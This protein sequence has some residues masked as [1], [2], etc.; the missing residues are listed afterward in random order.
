MNKRPRAPLHVV[1]GDGMAAPPTVRVRPSGSNDAYGHLVEELRDDLL[2]EPSPEEIAAFVEMTLYHFEGHFRGPAPPWRTWMR[3]AL[4]PV[5]ALLA[6]ALWWMSAPSTVT[7]DAHPRGA[8][9]A[10]STAAVAPSDSPE[11]RPEDWKSLAA[12]PAIAPERMGEGASADRTELRVAEAQGDTEPAVA[13]ERVRAG[14]RVRTE[15]HSSLKLVDPATAELRVGGSTTLFVAD[16]NSHRS[17]LELERGELRS[18]VQKRAA[19]QSYEVVTPYARISVVGTEFT[20]EHL[21]GRATI[22]RCSEGKVGVATRDGR[23][24]GY[25]EAGESLQVLPPSVSEAASELGGGSIEVAARE[26]WAELRAKDRRG[27]EIRALRPRQRHA[28]ARPSSPHPSARSSHDPRRDDSPVSGSPVA[29]AAAAAAGSMRGQGTPPV[30]SPTP[31]TAADATPPAPPAVPIRDEPR[32]KPQPVRL[33]S[34]APSSPSNPSKVAPLAPE[35]PLIRPESEVLAQGRALLV[36]GRDD[37]ALA[38]WR[39]YPH[40]GWRVWSALG[41]VYRIQRDW[42]QARSAYQQALARAPGGAPA[43]LLA[44]LA[45]TL[46]DGLGDQTAAS[47]VWRDYLDSHPQGSDA[48]TAHWHLAQYESGRGRNDAAEEHLRALVERFPAHRLAT[49]A[50]A[51]WGRAMVDG[52]AWADAES[53]FEAHRQSTVSERAEIALIGLTRVAVARGATSKADMLLA[54]YDRRFPAGRRANEAAHL[55]QAL[56]SGAP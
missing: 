20:V 24:L 11:E 40:K 32:Q 45:V 30:E 1:P 9:A 36:Q 28:P 47:R 39:G 50:L 7:S 38:L 42:A 5:A 29:A 23:M 4:A 43:R 48:A 10:G 44:D 31:A 35:A 33:A 16:W 13:Q 14:Q 49:R 8:A 12:A 56:E 22:V 17:R 6:I 54:E 26:P 37:E 41:D 15:P 52:R 25:V 46:A 21:P 53:L 55:R 51:R 19:D 2:V 3:W 27:V 18:T 34:V